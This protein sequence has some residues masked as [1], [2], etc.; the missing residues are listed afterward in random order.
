[1]ARTFEIEM[2]VE[3]EKSMLVTLLRLAPSICKL[4]DVPVFPVAGVMAV[5]IT[6]VAGSTR[7]ESALDRPD[8][9][10]TV[11][12]REPEAAVAA[13]CNRAVTDV[14]V[15]FRFETVR[16]VVEEKSMLVT[17][18]TFVPS[19]CKSSA[20]PACALAGVIAVICGTPRIVKAVALERPFELI[21]VSVRTPG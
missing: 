5:M 19:I 6:G 20:D 17:V 4:I 11:S 8:S 15:A 13:N 1:M 14:E 12:V 2:P 10:L 9:E 7:N 16:P 18:S 21:T 3:G